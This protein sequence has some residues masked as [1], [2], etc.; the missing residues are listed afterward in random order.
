[1]LL[2]WP[3]WYFRRKTKDRKRQVWLTKN[4]RIVNLRK[5]VKR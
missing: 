2:Y 3:F 4:K 1:M 5:G